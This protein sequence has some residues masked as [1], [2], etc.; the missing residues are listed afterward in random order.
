[1]IY[2]KG[3][4]NK[5][6]S[7]SGVPYEFQLLKKNLLYLLLDYLHSFIIIQLSKNGNALKNAIDTFFRLVGRRLYGKDNEDDERRMRVKQMTEEN[8]SYKTEI[9][10]LMNQMENIAIDYD[11]TV[12]EY[13]ADKK[14]YDERLRNARREADIYKVQIE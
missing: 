8:E 14:L 12:R 2:Y 11:Q 9:A 5:H 13:E 7:I 6:H 1:M 10:S 4:H 3:A